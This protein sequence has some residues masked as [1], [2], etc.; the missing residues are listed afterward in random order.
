MLRKLKLVLATSIVLTGGLTGFAVAKGF[1]KKAMKEK[2]DADKDGMLDDTERAT[3]KASFKTMRAERKKA[4][5]EKFDRNNDGTLDGAEQSA[6]KDERATKRFDTLDTNGD[7]MLSLEEFK[8]GKRGR[9]HH[10]GKGRR[11]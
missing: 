2:F 9:G 10:R 4:M 5:L 1:D 3:M 7:G 6:L 11:F 8:A